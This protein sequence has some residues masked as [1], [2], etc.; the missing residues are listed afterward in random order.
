MTETCS[1]RSGDLNAVRWYS[2]PGIQFTYRGQ[3]IGGFTTRRT[4]RIVLAERLV[5]DG[6]AV[7]HEMLHALL[8]RTGHPRS[9]FLGKCAAL[10]ECEDL[11]VKDAGPW[12]PPASNSLILAPDSL[13]VF[14]HAELLPRESD[15]ERW[16]ELMVTV[17]NPRPSAVVAIVPGGK[18]VL[19][20][21]G[22]DIRGSSGGHGG[23]IVDTD[24]SAVFFKPFEVKQ[25]LIEFR[26]GFST[27]RAEVLPGTYQ[28]SGYYGKVKLQPDTVIVA[29]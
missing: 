15:G 4:N 12:H 21:F 23:D 1:G 27:R 26:V 17:R 18:N 8:R 14:S 16:L 9:Q 7:R 24:S 11:C 29:P 6:P 10:V 20:T 28:V 5:D 2:V 19:D 22:Y 3:T 25:R 13:E